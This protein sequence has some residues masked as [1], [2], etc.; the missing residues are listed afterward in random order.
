MVVVA[1]EAVKE[2]GALAVVAEKAVTVEKEGG[3]FSSSSQEDG[4][5]GVE[6]GRVCRGGQ[7]GVDGGRRRWMC[8]PRRW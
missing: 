8:R 3:S 7:E 2:E 6:S 4:D 1:E 5:D